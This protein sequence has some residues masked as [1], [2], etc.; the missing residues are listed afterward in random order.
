MKRPPLVRRFASRSRG[1]LL[2]EV[3]VSGAILA[4]ILGGAISL[5]AAERAHIATATNRAK[6]SALAQELISQ[7]LADTGPTPTMVCGTNVDVPVDTTQYPG[8]SR[9]YSCSVLATAI[10]VDLGALY[11]L[12]VEVSYPKGKGQT[13]TVEH[14]ALRRD[15]HV[16]LE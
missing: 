15:R 6:A 12:T 11:E 7:L 1:Y 2:I 3:M 9:Q 4:V 14:K 13:G 16:L 5:I 10:N 8:F